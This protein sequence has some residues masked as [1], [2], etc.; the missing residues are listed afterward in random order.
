M[1]SPTPIFIS[2]NLEYTLAQNGISPQ[3]YLPA[4]GG[5]SAAL[6]LYC[7]SE[8]PITIRH[9]M[10][11]LIPTGLHI[12]LPVNRVALLQERGSISKTF[13]R[14]RAGVIDAGYTGEIFCS[15]FNY[16][17]SPTNPYYGETI[18]EP[19]QKLPFQLLVV[20]VFN[21]FKP[22]SLNEWTEVQSKS[23]RGTGALG[24]SDKSSS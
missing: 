13:L 11:A 10:S 15:C 3:D 21:E 9:G 1:S 22:L 20:P 18:I 12:S 16:T 2:S 8:H 7:T 17:N 23:A 14:L 6:D 19:N 5:E 24:S 4:Y